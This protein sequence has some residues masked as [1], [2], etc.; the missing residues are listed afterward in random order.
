MLVFLDDSNV[1]KQNQMYLDHMQ[2]CPHMKAVF[3][4]SNTNATSRCCTTH[5]EDNYNKASSVVLSQAQNDRQA[6]KAG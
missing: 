1:I 4:P 2:T 5:I 6:A 3:G